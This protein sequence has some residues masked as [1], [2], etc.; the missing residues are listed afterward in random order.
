[1]KRLT[2]MCL[3]FCIVI[4]AHAQQTI[5]IS[6][7]VTDSLGSIIKQTALVMVVD[8][9]TLTKVAGGEYTG[10]FRIGYV[11]EPEKAY[12]LYAFVPGYKD[13]YMEITGKSGNLGNI[14][15]SELSQ[16][17]KEV[18]VKADA[19]QHEVV[20]G[21]D[22]YKIS[23]S[24][25]ANEYSL[26]TL[27]SRIPGLFVDGKRVE[28]VGTG[29]PAFTIN[30]QKPR[31]GELDMVTPEEIE[32]VIVNR[33][34]SVKYGNSVKGV[35]DIRMKKKLRDYF[36]A[37]VRDDV[38]LGNRYTQNESTLQVNHKDGK[39]TNYLGYTYSF[40]KNRCD[41]YNQKETTVDEDK[42][43]NI[44]KDIE[45]H[46]NIGHQL[47]VSPKYQ[48]N[49]KSYVDIQYNYGFGNNNALAS[50]DGMYRN[51][52]GGLQEK[53][54]KQGTQD[55]ENPTHQVAARYYTE[56][57]NGSTFVTNV[58]YAN[59]KTESMQYIDEQINADRQV[60]QVESDTK[61]RVYTAD[62]DYLLPIASKFRLNMG[63]EYSLIQNE[64][65]TVYDGN[66][67]DGRS[68]HTDTKDYMGSLY[69]D[70]RFVRKKFMLGGGVRGEYNHRSDV[71]NEENNFHSL[72]F[73]PR[74]S[75]SY[76]FTPV[77][78]LSL[79]YNFVV[80]RPSMSQLNPNPIYVNKYLYIAGNPDLKLAKAHGVNLGIR[81]PQNLSFNV[82]YQYV[83]NNIFRAILSDKENPEINVFSFSNL[84]KTQNLML[85][86]NYWHIWSWYTF[87]VNGMYSKPFAKVPYLDGDKHYNKP[88]YV[89]HN[90]HMFRF[91]NGLS[92]SVALHYYSKSESFPSNTDA[93]Y[94]IGADLYYKYKQWNFSLSCNNIIYKK[95]VPTTQ[96]Y[97]NIYSRQEADLH[98]R[99]I[100]IGVTYRFSKFKDLFQKNK[101]GEGTIQRA[102]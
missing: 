18:V 15:L 47:T 98:M 94:N 71:Y 34:P 14:S 41:L 88:R 30:G 28:I 27:L 64:S 25:L 52:L 69:A 80:Q 61:S 67:L 57:K 49:E 45:K 73:S 22:V 86:A 38:E 55:S 33:A 89:V 83:K 20:F 3:L 16:K 26:Y 91:N 77:M 17:L 92:G 10:T 82:S 99:C 32:K 84:K 79:N 101:A 7:T 60:T 51:L 65:G 39:W 4:G 58:S 12:L 85:A 72:D 95:I 42:Y 11:A 54:D 2:I 87:Y 21:D 100:A 44:S 29:T 36:S 43:T 74:L 1:M 66:S 13:R 31:P 75:V 97:L 24:V 37:R 53:I 62:M 19:L 56:W 90:Q 23:G 76:S 81:L 48:I 78:A 63:W 9:T 93:H 46:R 68:F 96:R 40:G 70:L 35:I 5:E 6:G 50:T 8:K 102:N 59:L